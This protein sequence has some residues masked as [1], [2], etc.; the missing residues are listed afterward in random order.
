MR[1]LSLF[2]LFTGL[3]LPVA[4]AGGQTLDA[5]QEGLVR[6]RDGDLQ[7]AEAL[8]AKCAAADLA[9]PDVLLALA[10]ITYEDGRAWDSLDWSRQAVE[11]E[12]DSGEA[13]LWLGRALLAT[14]DAEAAQV[15]W[16]SGLAVDAEHPGLLRALAQRKLELGAEQAAYGLLSQ[17]VRIGG[18]DRWVLR[19]LSDLAAQRGL[20]GQAL[21]HWRTLMETVAPEA[22]DFR[23]AGELA[24]LAGDTTYAV[25]AAE[26]A[27]ER[28]PGPVSD[29][30]LG[31]AYF[32]ARRFQQAEQT[33][34]RALE[35][36]PS[37]HD[38]RF[39]LANALELQGRAEE[40]AAEFSTY[41]RVRPDDPNGF[42]NFSVHLEAQGLLEAAL[43]AA[44]RAAELAPRNTRFGI[45]LAE[46]LERR[47]DL[48]AA[49]DVIAT[50]LAEGAEPRDEL[51]RWQSLLAAARAESD[52]PENLDKLKLLHIALPDTAAWSAFSAELRAGY[53]FGTLATRYSVGLNAVNGGE[54]GWMDPEDLVDELAAAVR[55]LREREISPPVVSGGLIHIF[56]R[57]Q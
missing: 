38:S 42:H 18:A 8:L 25:V 23:H 19:T 2:F 54:I 12:P 37:L 53:D 48:P 57:T 50:L 41:V 21:Y 39:H 9:S 33:L 56:K 16:E 31:E 1:V 27:R 51:L 29:A 5:C 40:A 43:T 34:R 22:A 4:D 28:E 7:T 10:R 46:L 26:A 49:Q 45:H 14:G 24:I 36:D 13:R 17:L 35:A 3:L 32:A 6:L 20:W 55:G 47:P 44:G 52:R 15:Q 11:R 30:T